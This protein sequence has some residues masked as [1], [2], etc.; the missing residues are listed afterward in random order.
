VQR[1]PAAAR[2]LAPALGRALPGLRRP[3]IALDALSRG[4]EAARL[5]NWFPLF[6]REALPELLASD[7]PRPVVTGATERLIAGHLSRSDAVAPVNRMLYVD[8]KLW[9]SDY[10]LLRGDKLT[11]AASIE[12][13]VPLLDHKLVEF[14]ASLPAGLKLRGLT[15][16]YL[17]KRV[18]RSLLPSQIVDRKKQGFPIP[19]AA[20]FRNEARPVLRDMLAPDTIRRRGLFAPAYV[21]RLMDEHESGR[22]DHS[23]LLMGLLAVELWHRAFLDRRP[24]SGWHPVAAAADRQGGYES[25]CR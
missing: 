18:A 16:K 10:L 17:L 25:I 7:M 15:R 2:A 1:L 4:D 19:I 6:N 24:G 5:A 21:G 9:L 14:A 11:M 8:T 22:A 3:K 23:V 20:W 13:R 12:A